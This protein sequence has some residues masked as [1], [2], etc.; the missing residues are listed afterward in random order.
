MILW[1]RG[2]F[3]QEWVEHWRGAE[4][5]ERGDGLSGSARIRFQV[6]DAKIIG[7]EGWVWG[8]GGI[9]PSRLRLCGCICRGHSRRAC[10]II[11]YI[12]KHVSLTQD[13]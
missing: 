7:G 11:P 9:A 4:V 5:G 6:D 12:P 1:A 13:G 10:P 8:Q 2:D 3:C